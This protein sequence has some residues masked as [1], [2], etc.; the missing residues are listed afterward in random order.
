MT[1]RKQRPVRDTEFFIIQARKIHGDTYDYSKVVYKSSLEKVCIICSEHGEFWQTPNNH[2]RGRG[3][4]KCKGLYRY[5]KDDFIKKSNEVHHGVYDYSKVEYKNTQAK[6]CIICPKHGEFWQKPT[7]HMAGRG[8]PHEECV[9]EKRE[10]TCMAHFGVPNPGQDLGVREKMEA[11]NL[12]LYGV[13]NPMQ[14]RDVYLRQVENN[15]KKHGVK[16]TFQLQSVIDK[17]W[18]TKRKNH[19]CSSSKCE[20]KLYKMLLNVF[21]ASDIVS[22]YKSDEYPFRCDFYI[23]SRDLYIEL[24]GTWNH[25]GHWFDESN[26]DDLDMVMLY[27]S[28]GTDYYKGVVYDWTVR[29]VRKRKIAAEHKLNYV[30]FWGCKFADVEK[31]FELGCPDGRDWDHEYSWMH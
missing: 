20:K 8:C 23:K 16:S 17:G 30:V 31:W 15:L 22:P 19:T 29:D 26:Q 5:T 6:V 2:L 25:G 1:E 9:N 18:E 10:A 13:K 3:C 7:R 27:L 4:A 12:K 14:N 11:T 28:R 21:D 24:N